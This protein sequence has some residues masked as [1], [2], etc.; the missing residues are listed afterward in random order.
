MHA[1]RR[2]RSDL[3]PLMDIRL[4]LVIGSHAQRWYRNGPDLSVAEAARAWLD[5]PGQAISLPH[6]SPRN[7]AWL[8]RHPWFEKDVVPRLQRR[9][10]QARQ[11]T[12]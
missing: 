12:V 2:F 6:P 8:A 4:T 5:K 3:N 7:N 10:R 9:V 11:G 1:K